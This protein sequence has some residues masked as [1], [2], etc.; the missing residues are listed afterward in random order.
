MPSS[1]NSSDGHVAPLRAV[2]AS[3]AA[4]KPETAAG[5]DQLVGN[6]SIAQLQQAFAAESKGI[7]V[8]EFRTMGAH[9]GQWAA[10]TLDAA[11]ARPRHVRHRTD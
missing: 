2:R 11:F 10:R 7:T 5:L 1:K 4:F 6:R 9:V 3:L 8:A